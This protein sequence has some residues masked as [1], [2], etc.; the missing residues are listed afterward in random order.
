MNKVIIWI[1]ILLVLGA[2]FLLPGMKGYLYIAGTLWLAALCLVAK[3]WLPATLKAVFFV[4]VAIGLMYLAACEITI[5]SSAKTSR[6]LPKKYVVVLGA[7]IRG[8]N[9]TLSLIH[10]MQAAE[11][12]LETYPDTK[13]VLSGGQ[14][15]GENLS[16]AQCMFNWLTER[17]IAPDRL[18]LED[19]STST[20]ENLQFSEEK[21]L[22]DG[23]EMSDTAIISSP[24]HL[25]RAKSMA[26]SIGYVNPSGVACVHGYPIYSVGMYIREAFGLTHLWIF[27]D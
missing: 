21:I 10:R 4:L 7:G 27:G 6:D 16:E 23:G 9:P 25:Y 22:A 18:L 24:Y 13:A 2:G 26:G 1:I 14:G 11:S 20:M 3:T 19:K 12:Y 15:E 8:D 17:G 5:L